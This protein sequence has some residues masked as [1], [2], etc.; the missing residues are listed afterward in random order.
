MIRIKGFYVDS[1]PQLTY[2]TSPCLLYDHSGLTSQL[3][4]DFL[5]ICKSVKHL[6]IK[7]SGDSYKLFL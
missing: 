1:L 4:Y 5:V 7:M 2:Q 3:F 6:Q